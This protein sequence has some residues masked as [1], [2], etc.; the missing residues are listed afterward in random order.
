MRIGLFALLMAGALLS[1]AGPALAAPA[2][3]PA[4]RLSL[5]AETDSASFADAGRNAAARN[6]AAARAAQLTQ[7]TGAA[8]AAAAS[9]LCASGVVRAPNLARYGRLLVRNAEGA[10][11]PNIYDDAE[12]QPG[13]LIIEFAFGNG[14]AP[15]QAAIE[16]ALRCWRNPR[17]AGCAA[18]DMGP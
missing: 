2:G 11:E 6:A 10:A 18:E 8:F 7:A 17:G 4:C 12:E 13:A 16:A 5:R 3:R 15:A 9:H 1:A 14:G